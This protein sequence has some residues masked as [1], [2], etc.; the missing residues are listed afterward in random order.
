MVYLELSPVQLITLKA[1]V[2]KHTRDLKAYHDLGVVM[3]GSFVANL[4]YVS[5]LFDQISELLEMS[6]QSTEQQTG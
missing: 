6:S 2:L 3:E 5:T 4:E 1:I